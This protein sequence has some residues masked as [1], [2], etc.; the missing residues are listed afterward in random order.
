MTSTQ[1]LVISIIVVALLALGII[2]FA[3]NRSRKLR[4]RFGPE[5]NRA[6]QQSGSKYKAEA[7]LQRLEKRVS[8]YPLRSLSPSDRD[9]FQQSWREIQAT[10]VDDPNLAFADADQ[11]L[12]Q[13]MSARGYPMS[14][15]EHRAAEISVDHAMVVQ[16]YRAG[17]EI[18]LSQAKA[19]T[20][21]LRQGMIH[22]RTLFNELM[23][24]AAQ[25]RAH[26]AGKA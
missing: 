3:R 5:Y 20:E 26:A 19:T 2:L 7:E 17:H 21:D 13:V 12:G 6:V 18:A 9:R 22:Y 24:E 11:L 10:F 16:H 15:F 8:R 1:I 23:A 14:D 25:T 4:A